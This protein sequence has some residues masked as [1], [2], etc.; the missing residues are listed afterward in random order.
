MS[1][2]RHET[3]IKAYEKKF[4]N[5]QKEPFRQYI[6]IDSNQDKNK[7]PPAEKMSQEDIENL[8]GLLGFG[9]LIVWFICLIIFGPIVLLITLASWVVLLPIA[10][11]MSPP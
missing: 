9:F 11:A 3:L 8:L 4:G 6:D 7:K 2:K 10:S 5:I 1:T